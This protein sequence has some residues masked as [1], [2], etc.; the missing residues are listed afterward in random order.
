MNDLANQILNL[1]SVLNEP[2]NYVR[3]D[4]LLERILTELKATKTLPDLGNNFDVKLT[5]LPD[6][7]MSANFLIQLAAL[8]I[9]NQDLDLTTFFRTVPEAGSEVVVA[10]IK[11]WIIFLE[12]RK[13]NSK[14]EHE[15]PTGL[16]K[17][18][19]EKNQENVSQSM[20]F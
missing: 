13:H 2:L 9:V 20:F 11:G 7:S 18:L 19:N 6:C 15:L 8:Y 12:A 10:W 4:T 5:K 14:I 1:V 3:D 17:L 16:E